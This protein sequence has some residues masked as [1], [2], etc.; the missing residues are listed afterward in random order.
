MFWYQKKF[1]TFVKQVISPKVSS[2]DKILQKAMSRQRSLWWIFFLIFKRNLIYAAFL[3]IALIS[4]A[5]FAPFVLKN[6]FEL[7]LVPAFAEF[8]KKLLLSSLGIFGY[9]LVFIATF[10]IKQ[11]LF[12]HW[13]R[14]IEFNSL[15]IFAKICCY[16]LKDQKKIIVKKFSDEEG[17]FFSDKIKDL[18][19][20]F[21]HAFSLPALIVAFLFIYSIMQKLFI[22]PIIILLILFAFQISNKII[23]LR[24]LKKV[25][26]F[27]QA[28]SNI[29]QKIFIYGNRVHLLALENFFIKKVN[30]FQENSTNL[31]KG[32]LTRLSAAGLI[33]YFSGFIIAIPSLAVYLLVNQTYSFLTIAT[34]ITFFSLIDYFYGNILI[35]ISRVKDFKKSF[36]LF[37]MPIHLENKDSYDKNEKIFNNSEQQNRK[38]DSNQIKLSFHKAAFN[39]GNNICLYNINYEQQPGSL[40]AVIGQKNSGKSAFLS[41]CTGDLNIISGEKKL[42]HNVEVLSHETLLFDGTFRE[43]IIL[44]REFEGRRYVDVIRACSLENDFNSLDDGDETIFDSLLNKFP[45]Y[46]LRKITLART[47]YAKA[48]LYIFDEPFIGLTSN[49]ASIFFH[50]GIQ[51]ILANSSRLIATSKLEFAALC[52]EILVIKEGMLVEVGTHK[53]LLEKSGHYARLHYAAADA[54]QF[55]LTSVYQKIGDKINYYKADLPKEFYDFSYF[56]KTQEINYIRKLASS[57]KF[58][59][60]SYFNSS[61]TYLN[62]IY[63]ISSQILISAA[64]FTLFS[65]NLNQYIS[66]NVQIS[67]FLICSVF[68]LFLFYYYQLKNAKSNLIFSNDLEKKVYDVLIKEHKLSENVT[69][70]Y[71][72]KF[73]NV[74]ENLFQSFSS[75]IV[76]ISY[77]VA[78]LILFSVSN[79]TSL[80]ALLSVCIF[81]SMFLLIKKAAFL[82]AYFALKNEKKNLSKILFIYIRSLK[83]NN[84]FYFRE[85]IYKKISEKINLSLHKNSEKDKVVLSFSQFIC[86]ALL[87]ITMLSAIYFSLNIKRVS[88]DKVVLSF[89]AML[90]VFKA[91]INI[92]NDITTYFQTIPD[93]E[94]LVATA[95]RFHELEG[96]KFSTSN[97][98]P[99]KASIRIMELNVIAV[100]DYPQPIVNLDLYIPSGSKFGFILEKG[101]HKI[102]TLFASI[103]QFVPFESGSIVIDDEDILKLNPFDL[104]SKF[105]YI[106]MNSIFP[107]LTLKENLDPDELFDDSEIWSVLNRVG[108]AQSIAVLRNGLNTK[109]EDLPKQMLWAGETIFF[110]IAKALLQN[111]RIL[112]IDNII[113]TD[114]SEL[115]LIE[116]LLR[117]FSTATILLS[118]HSKSKLLSICNEVGQFDKGLLRRVNIDKF[119]YNQMLNHQVISD[120][121][122]Q[123]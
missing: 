114:E 81:T 59:L 91:F 100:K 32:I 39:D 7:F 2:V 14:Q 62:I 3:Q 63:L 67:L 34:L 79:L 61:S 74:K 43:N 52:D 90:F 111:N 19:A 49:E 54:R 26:F 113:L 104:R 36:H 58:F 110:S 116:I 6:Y 93:F 9:F 80:L 45:E 22:I 16:S 11:K 69:A 75:I 37:S 24:A 101:Q 109:I 56:D 31:V 64:F 66:R 5:L 12:T 86:F 118:V 107:F 99:E 25:A 38:L 48:D 72:E 41:A 95:S 117:E 60:K 85:F 98:W 121:I 78:A 57:N 97:Y 96:N 17:R 71:L 65:L 68:S 10:Y 94:E 33:Q 13:K 20:I 106:S 1:H 88:I 102:S 35:F 73:S 105:A 55:G 108:V 28:R 53:N 89:L 29:I 21:F 50:E 123:T 84:S 103:L 8:N 83:T 23:I 77:F 87:I 120:Y 42:V 92:S 76:R 119:D 46:F 47:L 18:P 27:I 82:K 40:S 4:L 51:K 30:L 115:R 15:D 70:K 44:D 112:L 122:S